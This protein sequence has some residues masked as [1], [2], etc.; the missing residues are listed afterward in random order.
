MAFGLALAAGPKRGARVV[1]LMLGVSAVLTGIV[2]CGG[3]S[4]ATNNLNTMSTPTG[5]YTLTLTGTG[6]GGS[7]TVHNVP[8]TLV[9]RPSGSP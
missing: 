2:A 3:G 7:G 5:T 1:L 6:N 8:I 9:V 4:N